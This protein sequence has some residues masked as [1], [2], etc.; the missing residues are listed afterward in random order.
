MIVPKRILDGLERYIEQGVPTG[1]FLRAVLSNDLFDAFARA[2]L[3]NRNTLFDIVSW[4][5]NNAPSNCHG[6]EKV[7]KDWLEKHRIKREG[8][9]K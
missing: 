6:S 8:A 7:Y 9:E 3:D 2:D 5:Y 1:G 4:I